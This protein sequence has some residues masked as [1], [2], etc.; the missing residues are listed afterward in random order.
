MYGSRYVVGVMTYF[1]MIYFFSYLF[2]YL[3]IRKDLIW[4]ESFEIKL[5]LYGSFFYK[6][7]YFGWH[8]STHHKNLCYLDSKQGNELFGLTT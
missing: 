5:Q 3:G 8:F 1:Q 7:F 6:V 4:L 2:S